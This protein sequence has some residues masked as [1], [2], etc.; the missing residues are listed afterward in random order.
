MADCPCPRCNGIDEMS[1]FFGGYEIV[2]QEEPAQGVSIYDQLDELYSKIKHNMSFDRK[3][4]LEILDEILEKID[5][6]DN[7]VVKLQKDCVKRKSDFTQF[8]LGEISKKLY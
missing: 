1:R 6:L 2:S 8:K 5:S 4:A 7:E 3:D